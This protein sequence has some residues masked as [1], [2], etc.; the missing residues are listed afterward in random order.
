MQLASRSSEIAELGAEVIAVS[1]DDD[2]RQAGMFSRWPTPSFTY[3]SDPGGEN[4]LKPLGV[5]DPV[6]R[7]GIAI[8]SMIVVSPDGEELYRSVAADAADRSEV[9]GL[10]EAL[11]EAGFETV[12]QGPGGPQAPEPTDLSGFF[13]PSRLNAYFTGGEY[14]CSAIM[15]RASGEEAKSLARGYRAMCRSFLSAWREVR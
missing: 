8:P 3:V 12:D 14:A 2:V 13:A 1:V 6:E 11:A 15:M 5:F 9:E 7:D 4:Y 10:F